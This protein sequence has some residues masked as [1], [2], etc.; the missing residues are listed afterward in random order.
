MQGSE[1]IKLRD[2][3]RMYDK[4]KETLKWIGENKE[5]LDLLIKRMEKAD[6]FQHQSKIEKEKRFRDVFTITDEEVEVAYPELKD[7]WQNDKSQYALD[8]RAKLT[9]D[10]VGLEKRLFKEIANNPI[11][12]RLY[13]STND[14]GFSDEYLSS[15]IIK[16][17][18]KHIEQL[19]E[20]LANKATSTMVDDIRKG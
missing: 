15:I 8:Y 16:E 14:L 19:E 11:V 7:D 10:E 13:D 2:F 17:L 6:D 20:K 9:Y 12:G 18:C 1:S 4:T 3:S 5:R